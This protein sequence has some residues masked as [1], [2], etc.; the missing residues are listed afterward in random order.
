VI[1]ES[2]THDRAAQ[3]GPASDGSLTRDALPFYF[4]VRRKAG[5]R[6][7]RGNASASF[8]DT[9]GVPGSSSIGVG[10]LLQES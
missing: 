4:A 3:G 1:S 6:E 9:D 5:A 8:P 2:R 10:V 7:S